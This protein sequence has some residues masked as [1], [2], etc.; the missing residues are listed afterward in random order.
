[1]DCGSP[2]FIGR[3]SGEHMPADGALKNARSR[4]TRR[5]ML[6]LCAD[7]GADLIPLAE[8]PYFPVGMDEREALKRESRESSKR[9]RAARAWSSTVTAARGTQGSAAGAGSARPR[10]SA[11]PS[12][13][14]RCAH[15]APALRGLGSQRMRLSVRRRSAPGPLAT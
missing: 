1:M 15:G 4:T 11:I 14:L 2:M 7:G 3:P 5:A 8:N 6:L 9:R 13:S 10:A 12:S